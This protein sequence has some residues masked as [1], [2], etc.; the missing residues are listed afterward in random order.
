MILLVVHDLPSV[1]ILHFRLFQGINSDMLLVTGVGIRRVMQRMI[2]SPGTSEF[3]RQTNRV[4]FLGSRM[5]LGFI[6]ILK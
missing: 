4:M 3:T 1:I 2:L 6:P 5:N